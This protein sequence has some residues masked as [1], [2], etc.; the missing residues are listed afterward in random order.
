MLWWLNS[1]ATYKSHNTDTH[2]SFKLH[3]SK[4]TVTPVLSQLSELSQRL[5]DATLIFHNCR[6]QLAG[7]LANHL[8][9]FVIDVTVLVDITVCNGSGFIPLYVATPAIYLCMC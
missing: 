1:F 3:E 9:L 5:L 7:Q 8:Q 2:A 6:S 4:I